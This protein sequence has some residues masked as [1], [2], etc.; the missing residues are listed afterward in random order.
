MRMSR[1]GRRFLYRQNLWVLC[2]LHAYAN[3]DVY[4]GDSQLHDQ[5]QSFMLGCQTVFCAILRYF[6]ALSLMSYPRNAA[7]RIA[8]SMSSQWSIPLLADPS[9]GDPMTS[10]LPTNPA[11]QSSPHPTQ[12]GVLPTI[13]PY[14]KPTL[15]QLGSWAGMTGVPVSIIFQNANPLFP[16]PL[17]NPKPGLER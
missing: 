13:R 9:P 15:E 16:P 8:S 7:L 10:P 6:Q 4:G 12:D 1:L 2:T 11:Q 14:V 17:N 5:D 3:F